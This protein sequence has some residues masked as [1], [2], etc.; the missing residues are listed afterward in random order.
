M[1]NAASLTIVLNAQDQA[2]KVIVGV[3]KS[4]S[5]L[6]KTLVDV[7]KTAAGV[8]IGTGLTK[9][10][11]IIAGV[12][13]SVGQLDLQLKKATTVL[14]EEKGAV[15]AWAKANAAAMGLTQSQAVGA[16][17]GFA[18]LLIPMGFTRAEAAKMSTDV[19]GLSGAL[20]EW[21]GGTKS[22]AEVSDVLAKAMLG[23]R[24]GLKALGISISEAD[25]AAKLAV[26]GTSELTGAALEQ[27]KAVATQ[28]LILEKSTDAQKAYAEGAG[29]AARKQAEMAARSMELKES[30][31]SALLPVMTEALGVFSKLPTELQAGVAAAATFGPALAPMAAGLAAVIPML[32]ALGVA[33]LTPPV[34]FVVALVAAG[35]AAY[36]FRDQIIG[37][38]GA[39]KDFIA[40]H[41]PEVAV[42]ISGPFAPLVILATDG[43]GLRTAIEGFFTS[44]IGFIEKT[45]TDAYN[46]ALGFGK[47]LG[48]GIVDGLASI[49]GVKEA[50]SVTNTIGGAAGDVVGGARDIFRAYG[51]PVRGGQSYVVGERGPELFVPNGSGTI[52]TW[53]QVNAMADE[54]RMAHAAEIEALGRR[55]GYTVFEDYSIAGPGT[56]AYAATQAGTWKGN[57]PMVWGDPAMAAGERKA[58]NEGLAAF[59][60]G[61]PVA[62]EWL[63]AYGPKGGVDGGA[64]QTIVINNEIMLDGATIARSV[65]QR[66]PSGNVSRRPQPGPDLSLAR[67][68]G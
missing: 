3:D 21:S 39:A 33:L 10:P 22:A 13:S 36:V 42:L 65:L 49:P 15:D 60:R 27:A 44:V 7:G 67:I 4:A 31:Q 26:N 24:D 50:L 62:S 2:T 45:A 47:Q 51:G 19:V 59:N 58:Y 40:G 68:A 9:A 1:T 43:F 5:G 28:Q 61:Q 37:A 64:A 38:F 35:V 23:E 41:W 32:G 29:S 46:A 63:S 56:A 25:V 57:G 55:L 16:A 34:G 8:A 52:M 48:Q 18:D 14:G 17:A 20:A 53:Q 11:G 66:M 6:K 54:W 12:A 30:M